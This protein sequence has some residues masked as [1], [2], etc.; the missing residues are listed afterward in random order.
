VTGGLGK[1]VAA[2]PAHAAAMAA[3]HAAC[4]PPRE[5]WSEAAMA[6]Q[7]AQPGA[8]GLIDPAGGMVLARVAADQAEILTLAV[9]PA[10]R[11]A[12][13]AAAL[14]RRAAGLAGAAGARALFLE[15]GLGNAPA[16]ALY[17]A[18]GFVAAGR[19][20]RYYADGSDALV[21]RRDITP[22]ATSGG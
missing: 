4:F 12:G 13:R 21:L 15:V 5:R 19:R 3:I 20:P 1:L 10:A 16:L 9:L 22:A 17:A 18:C 11:R 8:F 6:L 14:L 7:L 2:T